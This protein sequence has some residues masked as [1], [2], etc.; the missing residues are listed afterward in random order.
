MTTNEFP[1][2]VGRCP[3]AD[4][5]EMRIAAGAFSSRGIV[6]LWAMDDV[7]QIVGLVRLED[8]EDDAPL[9]DLRLGEAWRGRGI[10]TRVLRS[11][12]DYV[13]GSMP[14][15]RRF[16]GQ[17]RED[18]IAM[19]RTFERCGWVQEAHYREA[20]PVPDGEPIGSVAY[21]IIR[22]DWLRGTVTPVSF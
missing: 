7:Q 3:T 10:G 12:T 5:V 14:A 21:G 4:E 1:F 11:V 19:R 15:V 20:W 16:E 9:L 18:N 22:R 13:F 2:H 6:S 8:L 17:T